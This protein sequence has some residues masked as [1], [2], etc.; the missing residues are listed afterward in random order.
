MLKRLLTFIPIIC[1]ISIIMI[2]FILIV[3]LTLKQSSAVTFT[4]VGIYTFIV[5]VLFGTI[6]KKVYLAL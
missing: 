4:L 6:A 1:G 5:A 2:G 3:T